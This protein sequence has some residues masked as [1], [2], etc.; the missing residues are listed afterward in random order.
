[1]R[2]ACGIE[3]ERVLG[4]HG[5]LPLGAQ[6]LPIARQQ[7]RQIGDQ[8]HPGQ[9]PGGPILIERVSSRVAPACLNRVLAN[10]K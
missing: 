1:M 2:C 5:D 4:T 3:V 7:R 8:Q 6:A 10:A 9:P